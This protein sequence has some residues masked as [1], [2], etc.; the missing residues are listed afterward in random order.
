MYVCETTFMYVCETT[1]LNALSNAKKIEYNI[2]RSHQVLPLIHNTFL[3]LEKLQKKLS[4][5]V[6]KTQ[7]VAWSNLVKRVSK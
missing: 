7:G 3:H 4:S 2:G 6:L 5:H 1:F